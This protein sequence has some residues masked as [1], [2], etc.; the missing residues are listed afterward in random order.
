M[1]TI[2][3]IAL[4]AGVS[5][6]TVSRA[7]NTPNKVKEE[8]RERILAIAEE[9][10]YSPN[11]AARALATRKTGIIQIVVRSDIQAS[12]PYFM[13]LFVGIADYLSE[14]HY[15][16]QICRAFD[17]QNRSDGLIAMGLKFGE[18]QELFEKAKVPCVLFG[19]TE[20]P[21]DWVDVDNKDAIEQGI[22]Y[23][24]DGGH[25]NIGFMALDIQEHYAFERIDGYKET[26]EKA[27]IKV[28]DS[29]LVYAAD[30]K[31]VGIERAKQLLEDKSITAIMCSTD[32]LGISV[33]QAAKELGIHVP[34]QLCI[35][36]MDGIYLDQIASPHLTTIQQPV[37]EIG[38]ELA[39]TLLERL[40][41]LDQPIQRKRIKAQLLIQGTT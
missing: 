36:G 38:R 20:L 6:M 19:K 5:M 13:R 30:L 8:V 7:I 10:S 2:K 23:L 25:S 18:D 24:I 34:T 29:W 3:E 31:E 26:M 12:D 39:K 4:R 11:Q 32:R 14:Y 17:H 35:I 33:L 37:Y 15:S 40:N 21:I 27:G 41:D 9:L 16:I 1:S 22:T 28:K